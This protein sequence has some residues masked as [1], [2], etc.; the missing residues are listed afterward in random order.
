MEGDA[1]LFMRNDQVD[2]AWKVIMPILETWEARTPQDFP[3]YAPDSWGPD[4][5]DALLA[6][7]GHTWINLPPA[8]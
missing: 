8:P 3:N 6:R 5:S 7:D 1:T 4:G 2:A